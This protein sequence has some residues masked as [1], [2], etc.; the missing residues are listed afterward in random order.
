MVSSHWKKTEE[1]KFGIVGFNLLDSTFD[2][3][4][5]NDSFSIEFVNSNDFIWPENLK[6]VLMNDNLESVDKVSVGNVEP[7]SNQKCE[8]KIGDLK[9]R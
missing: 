3:D 4:V 9:G 1:I 6:A 8:F 2:M 5:T 7:H